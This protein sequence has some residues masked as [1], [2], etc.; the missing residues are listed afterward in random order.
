MKERGVPLP[1]RHP[2]PFA[3]ELTKFNRGKGE[4]NSN[5]RSFH[6]FLLADRKSQKRGPDCGMAIIQRSDR[7]IARWRGQKIA[8]DK[9]L[10]HGEG[11][12]LMWRGT[13]YMTSGGGG[14]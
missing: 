14:R 1:P 5:E 12:G 8:T 2:P 9:L 13:S 11:E 7:R 4:Q 3:L 6:L 10:I